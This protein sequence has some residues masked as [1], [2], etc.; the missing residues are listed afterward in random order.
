MRHSQRFPVEFDPS[1][2]KSKHRENRIAA[3][4]RE[5]AERIREIVERNEADLSSV[6]E[7]VIRRRMN[8]E[9]DPEGPLNLEEI[10][11][12]IGV[13]KE[14]VRQIQN[15]AL[16]KIREKMECY[17]DPKRRKK[18]DHK[19]KQEVLSPRLKKNRPSQ[20]TTD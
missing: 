18:A 11:K 1:M 10:G 14:R 3:V 7:T 17:L 13:T 19:G 8:W 16:F 5:L 20:T 9:E 6:E 15:R 4:E 2:E 12:I